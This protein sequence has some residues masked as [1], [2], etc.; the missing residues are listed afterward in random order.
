MKAIVQDKYGTAEVLR[1]EEIPQ[2]HPGDNEVLIRVHAAGVDPSVTHIMTGLPHLVRLA[3][4]FRRPR[5]RVRGFDVAGT[6]EAVGAQVTQFRP[7]DEVFGFS[8]GAFAEYATARANKIAPKPSN[9]TF[10]QA[11]V[12]P[13]SALT[14]LQGLRDKGSIQAG[15]RVLVIGAGGGVGIYAVQIAKAFGAHVTALCSTSK[16]DLVRSLGADEV[17]DYTRQDL[18]V[19][20][21]RYDIILDSAGRRP[22]SLL[23]SLLTPRGTLVLVGGEGGSQWLAGLDRTLAALIRSKR[24]SQRLTGMLASSKDADLLVMKELIEAG[25]VTPVIDR[26]FPLSE[27][28]EAVRLALAGHA[29]GKTVITI[30]SIEAPA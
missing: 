19:G 14:A 2:P 17:I 18:G 23:Q 24:G 27:A 15:Q 13:V 7:G 5:A 20:T 11:A 8:N 30:H 10:E 29:R 16:I 3:F 28:P 21:D 25:K 9:L 6:I 26:T 12:V 1:F 4:G 22:L